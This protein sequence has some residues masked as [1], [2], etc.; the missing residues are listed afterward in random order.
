MTPCC[1][2][3]PFPGL[4]DQ[5]FEGSC[6]KHKT[7]EAVLLTAAALCLQSTAQLRQG[8]LRHRAASGNSARGPRGDYHAAA[9]PGMARCRRAP[10][11]LAMLLLSL[12]LC[13]GSR[14]LQQSVASG[15]GG[16]LSVMAPATAT[17]AAAQAAAQKTLQL[18]APDTEATGGSMAMSGPASAPATQDDSL[19]APAAAPVLAASGPLP[20]GIVSLAKRKNSNKKKHAAVAAENANLATLSSPTT[21]QVASTCFD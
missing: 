5:A 11:A 18:A 19:A 7:Q 20:A 17:T 15:P 6:C 3:L 21:P 12:A 16:L 14:S 4:A 10:A 8:A 13:S 9:A 1:K 2:I